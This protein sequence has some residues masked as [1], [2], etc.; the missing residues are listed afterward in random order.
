MTMT[1]VMRNMPTGLRVGVAPSDSPTVREG[2][3]GLESDLKLA[4]FR[5]GEAERGYYKA[6]DE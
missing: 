5:F 2:A 1:T 4:Q 3:N 6:D